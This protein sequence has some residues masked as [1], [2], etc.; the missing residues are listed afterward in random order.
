MKAISNKMIR[1]DLKKISSTG[2]YW[3]EKLS[4]RDEKLVRGRK[5]KV[6]AKFQ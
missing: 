3:A 4:K 1:F 6:K 5:L 2:F